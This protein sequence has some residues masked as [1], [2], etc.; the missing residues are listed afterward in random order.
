M[1]NYE[2]MR[3]EIKAMIERNKGKEFADTIN[4]TV[5]KCALEYAAFD[6]NEKAFKAVIKTIKQS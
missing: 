6:M 1:E 2:I 4:A 3:D 5:L